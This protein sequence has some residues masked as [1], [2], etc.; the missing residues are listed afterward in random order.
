MTRKVWKKYGPKV[1]VVGAPLAVLAV[2][3]QAALDAGA[4]A[5]FTSLSTDGLLV[6]AAAYP[7]MLALRG[8]WIIFGMVKAGLSRSK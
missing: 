4:T 1:A 8:G 7:V 3:S 2:G 5:A 6:I